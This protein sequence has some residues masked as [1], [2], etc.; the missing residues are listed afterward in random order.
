LSPDHQLWSLGSDG[1]VWRWDLDRGAGRPIDQGGQVA[2]HV[3]WTP[4]GM[5]WTTAHGLVL[6]DAAERPLRTL[7]YE[8]PIVKRS[9]ADLFAVA[10]TG[11]PIYL[12]SVRSPERRRV[13]GASHV[14]PMAFSLDERWLAAGSDDGSI[15]VWRVADGA[16]AAATHDRRRTEFVAL[17]PD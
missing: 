14:V 1:R 10:S 16:V 11:Q 12:H 4:S 15:H 2:S 8:D 17:S 5:A 9:T 7:A 3:M 6:A 13:S